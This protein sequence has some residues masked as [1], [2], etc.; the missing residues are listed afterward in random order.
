M[1]KHGSIAIAEKDRNMIRR[2]IN[3]ESIAVIAVHQQMISPDLSENS[4]NKEN[5]EIK[6]TNEGIDALV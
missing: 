3:N 6:E 5:E 1:K 4:M 2:K